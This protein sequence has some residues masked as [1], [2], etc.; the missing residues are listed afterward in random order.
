MLSDRYTNGEWVVQNRSSLLSLAMK[1]LNINSDLIVDLGCGKGIYSKRLVQIFSKCSLLIGID[2]S[3][4]NIRAAKTLQKGGKT[5]FIL[6]DG[7]YLPFKDKSIDAVI[8]KDILHHANHPT[9]V[10][11]EVI[12]I[13][14]GPSV[15]IEANK[16]NP[17]MALNEK[18]GH[19]HLTGKQLEYLAKASGALNYDI[20]NSYDYPFTMRLPSTN[21]IAYIWN[22]SASLLL[23]SCNGIPQIA[24]FFS[25]VLHLLVHSYNGLSINSTNSSRT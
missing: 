7:H 22:V 3:Q 9:R 17:I 16:S 1:N 2:I 10:L 25:Q 24:K 15:V 13:S 21:P 5:E 20:F 12:R 6:A 8:S 18:Y 14:K 23:V 11:K 4:E 19:H